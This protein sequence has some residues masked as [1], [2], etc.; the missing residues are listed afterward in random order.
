[1]RLIRSRIG[2]GV[3]VTLFL[4]TPL[5]ASSAFEEE[6]SSNPTALNWAYHYEASEVLAEIRGLS[7]RLADDTQFLA[8]QSRWNQLSW[9]S[10]AQYLNDIRWRI[11]R[12][13]EK[14]SRLQEISGMIAPWQQKA[15]ER[16]MPKAMALA[17]R[18]EGAIAFLN[19]QQGNMWSAPYTEHVNAMADH[20]EE[21]KS[22]VSMFLDYGKTSGHFDGL[23]SQIEYSGA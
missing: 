19:E 4:V 7:A 8:L 20:A 3:V 5:F 17:E 18:T 12:M 15:I 9:E 21:I 14:L 16:V 13:G 10:H 2:W 6:T 22:T 1:M 11:N 23:E